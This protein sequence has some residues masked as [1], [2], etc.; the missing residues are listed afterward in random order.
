LANVFQYVLTKGS[1]LNNLPNWILE[2]RKVDK[3][4]IKTKLKIGE[5]GDN[6]IVFLALMTS[7]AGFMVG[8]LVYLTNHTRD[9]LVKTDVCNWKTNT[10]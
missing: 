1:T 2:I 3:N 5:L 7:I 10:T 4:V 8:N 6:S 9:K